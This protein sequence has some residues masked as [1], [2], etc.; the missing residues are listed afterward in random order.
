MYNPEAAPL[1][2]NWDHP[3]VPRIAPNGLCNWLLA[4]TLGQVTALLFPHD[5]TGKLLEGHTPFVVIPDT[6]SRLVSR[7]V[8][9]GRRDSAQVP[10]KGSWYFR[11]VHNVLCFCSTVFRQHGRQWISLTLTFSDQQ[12]QANNPSEASEAS[13]ASEGQE[14]TAAI[15]MPRTFPNKARKDDF[16][17]IA[18][19]ESKNKKRKTE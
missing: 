10:E 8:F 13:E 17:R 9:A 1:P 16:D 6:S 3:C 11:T 2:C 12:H 18:G 4:Y 19:I 14:W 15:Q 5:H 7:A